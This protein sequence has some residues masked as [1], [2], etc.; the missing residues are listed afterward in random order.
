M[1]K[2]YDAEE[3]SA[4]MAD[5]CSALN[6]YEAGANSLEAAYNKYVHNATFK[7]LLADTAKRC[8]DRGQRNLHKENLVI[9]NKL[10]AR[11][12]DMKDLFEYMVDSSP[13]SRID[14]DVLE[15]VKKDFQGYRKVVSTHGEKIE[16][17]AKYLQDNFSEDCD[18]DF[19]QPSYQ[20]ARDAYSKFSGPKGFID[21]TIEKFEEFDEEACAALTRSGIQAYIYDYQQELRQI[22]NNLLGMNSETPKVD[23][24][25]LKNI[26]GGAAFSAK[27]MQLSDSNKD[28]SYVS[29]LDN[30]NVDKWLSPN[31]K[32][33]AEEV[34]EARKIALKEFDSF[35]KMNG[36]KP[37][38]QTK[39]DEE[40]YN[41]AS[42]LFN[43]CSP[44]IAFGQGFCCLLDVYGILAEYAV[45]DIIVG[46]FGEIG[47]TM[48][49]NTFGTDTLSDVKE[50]RDNM[51]RYIGLKEA[52]L[53]IARQ[54]TKLQNPDAYAI[55]SFTSEALMYFLTEGFFA[56]AAE[57][58]NLSKFATIQ[59][60]ENLQDLMLDT[61]GVYAELIE[62]GNLSGSDWAIIGQ[63]VLL[64]G[65][66]N[67]AFGQISEIFD[68]M[69][70]NKASGSVDL[71]KIANG[72]E[73]TSD[74]IKAADE[75]NTSFKIGDDSEKII[76]D[77]SQFE[78]GK[79]KSNIKYQTGEHEYI[80]ETNGDGLIVHASTENLQ[81]KI[82]SGRLRHDPNS[83]GKEIGDHSGHIFGD[84]FGGSPELDNLVSQ[85]RRVN[86]SEYCII[87]N[88]WA[89][90]LENGKK[91]TVDIDINYDGISERPTSFDISYT[92]DDVPFFKHI[93]N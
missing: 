20:E 10:L 38:F 77:G 37:D 91:V 86:Q 49:D 73:D 83:F 41:K 88:E 54:N 60:G 75:A 33:T 36:N 68:L 27:A 70:A 18:V 76:T 40:R 44:V 15:D 64:N 85:A 16:D 80:Y 74:T 67:L 29:I 61:T 63:N 57:G 78:N 39:E 12:K 13:K 53:K 6:G 28:N 7:G 82:H 66:N 81:P 47:A 92:I 90:A 59:A 46:G 23:E 26:V 79:L 87:E 19:T 5:L 32:M 62:D 17:I 24:T 30:P 43:K 72:A 51:Q 84:R 14:T 3:V 71:N 89:K 22:G 50:L 4:F 21:K 93:D 52:D 55:G 45:E 35:E 11:Y 25:I 31:Y 1:G 48:I 69:K 42:A 9:Q 34:A 58:L 56:G 8:I 2:R 65:M